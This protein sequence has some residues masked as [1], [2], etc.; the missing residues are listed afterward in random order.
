MGQE[1]QGEALHTEWGERMKELDMGCRA[2]WRCGEKE[3]QIK[4]TRGSESRK[5]ASPPGVSEQGVGG[6][7]EWKKEEG[8]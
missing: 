8:V 6:E 4:A 3:D 5:V 1:H 2:A 7:G